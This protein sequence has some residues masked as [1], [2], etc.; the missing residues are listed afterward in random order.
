MVI[1]GFSAM[2]YSNH[3]T[4]FKFDRICEAEEGVFNQVTPIADLRDCA[5]FI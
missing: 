5:M 1:T 4:I 3:G 2:V